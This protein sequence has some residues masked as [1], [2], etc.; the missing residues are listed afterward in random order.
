MSEDGLVRICLSAFT[1]DQVDTSWTLLSQS[2][3]V[4]HKPKTTRKGQGKENRILNDIIN[5][6][7][8]VEPDVIPVFVARDLEKLP[9]VTFDHVDVTKLLKDITLMQSEIKNI[10][11]SYVTLE[12][13]QHM[14]NEI[15]RDRIS[16]PPTNNINSKRGA[17]CSYGSPITPTTITKEYSMHKSNE[18]TFSTSMLYKEGTLKL[19]PRKNNGSRLRQNERYER[20]PSSHSLAMTSHERHEVS[21]KQP[22]RSPNKSD[23]TNVNNIERNEGWITVQRRKQYKK[24]Q[25]SGRIGTADILNTFKAAERKIPI[26]ITN[27]HKDTLEADI[28]EYIYKNTKESVELEKIDIKKSSEYCAYK[29][30]VCS[31]KKHLFLDEK[32]WPKGS[33]IFREFIHFNINV[34]MSFAPTASHI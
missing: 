1:R 3:P 18:K 24:K 12:K 19:T 27:V 15:K 4:E 13:F 21:I 25:L 7:K 32:L 11:S 34:H 23:M 28:C 5:L 33:I 10:K 2:I 22:M 26:F 14:E 16:S 9:P 8:T 20:S 31:L 30:F 29:F 17:G 6:L